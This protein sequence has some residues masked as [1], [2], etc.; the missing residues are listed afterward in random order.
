MPM[1]QMCPRPERHV[2]LPLPH[3]TISMR[4]ILTAVLAVA[5]VGCASVRP[6]HT[7]L[8]GCDHESG[9]CTEIREVAEESFL[10]AQL[11]AN[12]YGDTPQ[13][14][15]PDYVVLDSAV[16]DARTGFAA[17]I[18]TILAGDQPVRRVI[19]YRGTENLRDWWYGN[20]LARQNQHGLRI[21]DAVRAETRAS[22][23]VDVTGHSL[24][25]GLALHV[26]LRRE[27]V[28]T[29][30][31]NSS[32]RFTRGE[33]LNSPRISIAEHGEAL[34]IGRV[35]AISPQQSHTVIGCTRGGPLRKHGQARL[36]VCLTEIAAWETNAARESLELNASLFRRGSK[37]AG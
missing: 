26:S 13:F 2:P 9:W 1:L 17:A 8:T 24:G 31:F 20:V 5:L 28:P 27:G 23:P 6:A 34:K 32:P 12:A 22:I 30:V 14:V 3:A 7:P 21:Y 15:L 10:Y 25:G 11:A 36:A 16:H 18:F 37:E 35:F 33:A 19:A 29:Y 4:S